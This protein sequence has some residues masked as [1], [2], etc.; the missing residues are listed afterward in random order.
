MAF[1]GHVSPT[2]L[3]WGGI[4]ASGGIE[5]GG[6]GVVVRVG[7]RHDCGFQFGCAALRRAARPLMC[8]HEI[9]VPVVID[10]H[11]KIGSEQSHY[12]P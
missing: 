1:W 9:D 11:E 10:Q 8:G 5:E 6:I 2:G 4:R 7:S 12:Q 3:P